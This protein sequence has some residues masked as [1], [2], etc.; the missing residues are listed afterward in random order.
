MKLH[1]NQP[2]NVLVNM[3]RVV[4]KA[5]GKNVEVVMVSDEQRAT[6]EYKAV[7]PTNKFPLLETPEGNVQESMTV[8]KFLAHGH[9]TL[10]GKNATERAQVDQWTT[11]IIAGTYQKSYPALM[12]IFGMQPVEQAEFKTSVD[13]VKANVRKLDSA[14]KG[15]WLVGNSCTV[16]DITVA[17]ILAVGF[18]TILDGG[19]KKAAPKACAW[20]ARVTALPEF[21][22]VFGRVKQCEKCLKPVLKAKEAPKKKVE[23]KKA[24]T[25]EEKAADLMKGNPLDNLPPSPWDFFNFKTLYVNH[26]DKRGAGMEELKKQFDAEGYAFWYVHYDKFGDEG[27]VFDHFRKHALGKLNMIGAEPDLDI[28]GVFVFRGTVMP[29]EAIDHPQFEYMQAR[30]MDPNNADDWNLIGQHWGVPKTEGATC[31]GKPVVIS[32]WHK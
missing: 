7:N 1:A 32:S 14:L 4:A 5:A 31:E 30:K 25:A 13:D 20:F 28:R 12:A 27:K 10:L 22:S 9:A 2:F 3:C 24:K 15:D 19:F 11:W 6:K 26:P 16:A 23:P 17:S 21:K 8:A 29:Q 18:Q